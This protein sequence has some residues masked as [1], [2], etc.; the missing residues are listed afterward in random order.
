[1]LEI[2]EAANDY[3]KGL[4]KS[5][6]RFMFTERDFEEYSQ[7]LNINDRGMMGILRIDAIGVNLPIFHGTGEDVL[8]LGVGH[9]EG[10]SLPVGGLGT[11]TVITGHNGL[12]SSILLTNLDRMTIGDV[13]AINVLG[14]LLFYQV[15]QTTVIEPYDYSYMQLYH[16]KDYVTLMTCTPYG[17]NSHRLLVRGERIENEEIAETHAAAPEEKAGDDYWTVIAIAAIGLLFVIVAFAAKRSQKKRS[18]QR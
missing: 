6:N 9:L 8:A 15:D 1:M 10:S 3:N 5:N 18:R 16:D 13:F 7:Q 17:I 12:P 14:E 4:R 2:L 11:H